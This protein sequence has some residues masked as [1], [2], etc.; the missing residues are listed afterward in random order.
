MALLLTLSPVSATTISGY[1]IPGGMYGG[2]SGYYEWINYCP[3]CGNY[4]CLLL[5]PKGTVEGELSCA[6]CDSDFDGCT[7]ADKHA[8][9]AWGWLTPY[10]PE[11][12]Q[13][14]VNK[15]APKSETK[16]EKYQRLFREKEAEILS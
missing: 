13:K 15:T 11:P 9:G 14:S 8:D 3:N 1:F 12:P 2:T 16:V 6:I 4:D 10:T 7:G 5:N